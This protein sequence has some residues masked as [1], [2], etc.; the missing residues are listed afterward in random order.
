MCLEFLLEYPDLGPDLIKNGWNPEDAYIPGD[1]LS[2]STVMWK[3][4]LQPDYV[5][6]AIDSLCNLGVRI[7]SMYLLPQ[8]PSIVPMFKTEVENA[9]RRNGLPPVIIGHSYEDPPYTDDELITRLY[10]LTGVAHTADTLYSADEQFD[11]NVIIMILQYSGFIHPSMRD[12]VERMRQAE[13]GWTPRPLTADEIHRDEDIKSKCLGMRKKWFD[14][15]FN[16]H[17]MF[18]EVAQAVEADRQKWKRERLIDDDE[19]TVVPYRQREE[20]KERDPSKYKRRS[21]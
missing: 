1:R 12:G 6:R 19:R 20:E 11:P 4:P 5:A 13:Y 10:E 21:M 16:A 9:L 8:H 14:S 3:F 7:R 17:D 2:L 18:V 15:K